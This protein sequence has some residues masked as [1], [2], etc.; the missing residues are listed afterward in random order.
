MEKFVFLFGD[1]NI[2]FYLCITT[3]RNK[4]SPY[5]EFGDIS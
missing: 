2:N 5:G 3:R 1:L 4:C